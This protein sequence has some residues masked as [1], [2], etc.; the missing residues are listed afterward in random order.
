MPN[1]N[2]RKCASCGSTKMLDGNK[3]LLYFVPKG[4]FKLFGN[5]V[6]RSLCLDCGFVGHY[7]KESDLAKI[8]RQ[9]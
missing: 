3:D 1:S 9:S 5:P 4:R 6:M 2:D 7:I 8:R